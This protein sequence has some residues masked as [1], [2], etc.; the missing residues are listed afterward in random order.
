MRIAARTAVV[1]II[2]NFPRMVFK[3]EPLE[4]DTDHRDI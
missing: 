4:I 2:N 1:R 3:G